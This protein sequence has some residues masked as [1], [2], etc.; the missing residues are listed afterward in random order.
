MNPA[1]SVGLTIYNLHEHHLQVTWDEFRRRFPPF[2]CRIST[3]FTED[4]YNLTIEPLPHEYLDEWL[5]YLEPHYS[6]HVY[7]L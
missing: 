3:E 6:Y 5:N 2:P 1:D 4:G 7:R